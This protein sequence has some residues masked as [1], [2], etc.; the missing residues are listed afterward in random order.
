MESPISI[1]SE[2]KSTDRQG[3]NGHQASNGHNGHSNT[4]IPRSETGKVVSET[5]YW[6]DYYEHPEFTYEWKQRHLGG[7]ADG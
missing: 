4:A 5:V 3:Q 1:S 2:S 7:E 6:R